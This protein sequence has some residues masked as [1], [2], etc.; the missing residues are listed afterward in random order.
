MNDDVAA[1]AELGCAV[2]LGQGD[3]GVEAARR[4]GIAFGRSTG[5]VE[6]ARRAEAE[7][8]LYVG[9]GAVWETPSKA[10]AGPAI[11]L[12]GLGAICRA[13]RLPVIAIGGVDSTNTASCI[14]A[15]AAGV[16]V[17]R[18]VTELPLLRA[19]LDAALTARAAQTSP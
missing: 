10:D 5:S 6:E 7:G 12:D 8:A 2:H 14:A 17:I 4:A 9:A 18:A 19:V 1:A 11:G 16:A 3:R 13:V 15:G